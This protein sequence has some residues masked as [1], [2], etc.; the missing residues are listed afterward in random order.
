[1]QGRHGYFREIL[2]VSPDPFE[3]IFTRNWQ[4]RVTKTGNCPVVVPI[5]ERYYWVKKTM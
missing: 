2:Q 3:T 5:L 1:M 4:I